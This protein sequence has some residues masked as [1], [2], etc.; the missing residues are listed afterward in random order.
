MRVVLTQGTTCCQHPADKKNPCVHQKTQRTCKNL[1]EVLPAL[2]TFAKHENCEPTN[3]TAEQQARIIV[4]MRKLSFGSKSEGGSRY[5]ESI[6]TAAATLHKQGRA[7]LPF[8]VAVLTAV[9]TGEQPPSLLRPVTT[10][11]TTSTGA[12]ANDT[13]PLPA[14]V[15]T[16]VR[17]QPPPP[18]ATLQQALPPTRTP[19]F[20]SV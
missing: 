3:N 13:S 17:R 11:P 8:L 20:T 12:V 6:L 18:R 15:A 14:E 10:Q 1:L 19:V 5:M 7:L 4:I 9:L 16:E 2:F